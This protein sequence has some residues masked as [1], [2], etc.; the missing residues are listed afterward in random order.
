MREIEREQHE[1]FSTDIQ[2]TFSLHF[3]FYYTHI[4]L[5]RNCTQNMFLFFS[6]MDKGICGN[7]N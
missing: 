1:L 7:E 5:F 2:K 3:L 4:T 6:L